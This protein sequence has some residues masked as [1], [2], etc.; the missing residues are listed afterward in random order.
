MPKTQ[1]RH[2]LWLRAPLEVVAA[3]LQL[4]LPRDPAAL[5]RY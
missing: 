3:K 1:A 2:D 4:W 5:I